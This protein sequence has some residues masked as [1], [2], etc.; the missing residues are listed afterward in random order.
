MSVT[1]KTFV[2]DVDGVGHFVFRNRV[3]RDEFKIE[4]EIA[5]LTEGVPEP[6]PM[7]TAMAN[8]VAPL[9]VLAVEV[10]E[11][12]DID[13]M[14]PLDPEVFGR[15]AAVRKALAEKEKFFRSERRAPGAATG[16]GATADGT[17]VV[18]PKV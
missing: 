4:A 8:T 16:Q 17:V 10:P 6:T 14:D 15:L 9:K 2:V 7:L 13:A 1:A 3:M 5:R 11:G 12:W 18:P